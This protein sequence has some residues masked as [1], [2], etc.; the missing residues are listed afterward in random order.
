M[1]RLRTAKY[2]RYFRL[3]SELESKIYLTTVLKYFWVICEST[4]KMLS[5]FFKGSAL[6]T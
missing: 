6:K 2:V 3:I 1:L 4:V 5:M